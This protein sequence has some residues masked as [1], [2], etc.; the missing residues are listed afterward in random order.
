MSPKNTWT[1]TKHPRIARLVILGV[2][3]SISAFAQ[4]AKLAPDKQAKL[5]AIIAR[6][7]AA[8]QIPGVS[9][10]VARRV[11]PDPGFHLRFP[12]GE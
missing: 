3:F 4:D 11:D 2:L 12:P 1:M 10:G 6:F 9:V 5:E 7:M 8:N